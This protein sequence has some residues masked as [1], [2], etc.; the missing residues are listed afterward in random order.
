MSLHNAVWS[1]SS[2]AGPIKLTLPVSMCFSELLLGFHFLSFPIIINSAVIA[3]L[4]E[5]VSVWTVSVSS[6]LV[7]C[8]LDGL[9][10]IV[11]IL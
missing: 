5:F 6:C 1:P 8:N 11:S 10:T 3:G 7:E 2:V 4:I 9:F